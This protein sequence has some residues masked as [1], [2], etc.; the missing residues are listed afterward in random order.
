MITI[1]VALVPFVIACAIFLVSFFT[2]CFENDGTVL[3]SFVVLVLSVGVY[4]AFYGFF[5][6]LGLL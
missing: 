1:T 2:V 6:A 4:F 3:F 5:V